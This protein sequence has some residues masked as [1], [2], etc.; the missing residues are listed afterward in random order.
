MVKKERINGKMIST[1]YFHSYYVRLSIQF[2]KTFNSERKTDSKIL[3]S[4]ISESGELFA[5]VYMKGDQLI[6][7]ELLTKNH[8]QNRKMN[9]HCLPEI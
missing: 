4:T 7:L 5:R 1:S 2:R 6:I 3:Q 8:I 9:P